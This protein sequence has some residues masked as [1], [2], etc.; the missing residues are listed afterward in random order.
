MN[1]IQ[2]IRWQLDD[3]SEADNSD[4]DSTDFGNT[5]YDADEGLD[6]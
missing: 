1:Q 2:T 6:Q 4:V 3:S 5:D